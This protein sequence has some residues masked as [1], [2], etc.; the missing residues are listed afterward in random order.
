MQFVADC[1]QVSKTSYVIFVV[2]FF[3]SIPDNGNWLY[4]EK[5]TL[6]PKKKVEDS[7][8]I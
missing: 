5:S 8:L 3:K 4:P 6:P 1:M 7:S 2:L